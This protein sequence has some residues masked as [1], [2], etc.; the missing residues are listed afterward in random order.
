MGISPANILNVTVGQA[1]G[2]IAGFI[3]PCRFIAL[4][5]LVALEGIGDKGTLGL[6]RIIQISPGQANT[7]D[8]KLADHT[9]GDRCQVLI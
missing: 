3:Q 7:T 8:I 9:D 2:K 6:L 4:L 1:A 5:L